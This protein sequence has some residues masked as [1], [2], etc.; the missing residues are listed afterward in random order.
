MKKM[1][2][3]CL[4]IAASIGT[5]AQTVTIPDVHF[6]SWLTANIPSA[7][8]GNQMDTSNVTV[9]SLTSINISYDSIA[10][11]T[12][13]EYFHSLQLLDCSANQIVFINALPA[14]LQTL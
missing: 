4:L 1:L 14:S 13:I 12:G 10:D 11:I 9:T 5:K 3:F 8:S 7:M 2:L 6:V